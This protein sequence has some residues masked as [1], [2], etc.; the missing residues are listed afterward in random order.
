MKVSK[1][2]Q[3]YCSTHTITQ[4]E[5]ALLHARR[6]EAALLRLYHDEDSGMPMTARADRYWVNAHEFRELATELAICLVAMREDQDQ[7][8]FD[9]D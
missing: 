3:L 4:V 8:P 2:V 7:P 6:R 9:P 1:E 5:V